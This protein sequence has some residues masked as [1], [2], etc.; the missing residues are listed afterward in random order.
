MEFKLALLVPFLLTCSIWAENLHEHRNEHNAYNWYKQPNRVEFVHDQWFNQSNFKTAQTTCENIHNAPLQELSSENPNKSILNALKSFCHVYLDIEADCINTEAPDRR[1]ELCSRRSFEAKALHHNFTHEFIGYFP[2]SV[3]PGTETQWKHVFTYYWCFS[4]DENYSFSPSSDYW[5][6]NQWRDPLKN[7]IAIHQC[8][9]MKS[10]LGVPHLKAN[11]EIKQQLNEAEIH[12]KNLVDTETNTLNFRKST[13]SM[14]TL[15]NFNLNSETICWKTEI[16]QIEPI[17]CTEAQVIEELRTTWNLEKSTEIEAFLLLQDALKFLNISKNHCI[18]DEEPGQENCV[19]TEGRKRDWKLFRHQTTGR[20]LQVN[21]DKSFAS[22]FQIF[23]PENH[24]VFGNV[25]IQLDFGQ[26]F[27]CSNWE[28][29]KLEDFQ[30]TTL[31]QWLE[32]I[33]DLF[34]DRKLEIDNGE[35][36]GKREWGCVLSKWWNFER[37]CLDE[38]NEIVKQRTN[39]QELIDNTKFLHCPDLVFPTSQHSGCAK[40]D[41]S[42]YNFIFGKTEGFF[43]FPPIHE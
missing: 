27:L 1:Y 22:P 10:V 5:I 32:I 26:T 37:I 4:F 38:N 12:L 34:H 18:G 28:N 15:P 25:C 24:L 35:C 30:R 40:K 23:E 8:S 21:G 6:W 2:K 7:N 14:T 42:R 19:L 41:L 43:N 16:T 17:V 3:K 9:R 36:G 33:L 11:G 20:I 29:V 39:W 13:F 31:F